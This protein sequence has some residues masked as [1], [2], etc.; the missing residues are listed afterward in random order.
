MQLAIMCAATLLVRR[1]F[2]THMER[3][4]VPL[5]QYLTDG[6]TMLLTLAILIMNLGLYV[7]GVSNTEPEY[8]IKSLTKSSSFILLLMP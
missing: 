3:T 7:P 8:F 6:R 2:R 1:R 4:A 5:R